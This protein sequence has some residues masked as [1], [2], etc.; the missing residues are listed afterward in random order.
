MLGREL[1]C[2][3][4][5]LRFIRQPRLLG[6]AQDEGRLL[7]RGC[8][9]CDAVPC[10]TTWWSG[11]VQHIAAR[12]HSMTIK[13]CAHTWPSGFCTMRQL[14][15]QSQPLGRATGSAPFQVHSEP[16]CHCWCIPSI[17]TCSQHLSMLHVGDTLNKARAHQ[18]SLL[19]PNPAG[20]H[21]AALQHAHQRPQIKAS[22]AV[23]ELPPFTPPP[24]DTPQ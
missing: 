3:Q 11:A 19:Q 9:C 20:T 5:F 7:M 24:V 2:P 8:T 6:Q 16:S 17:L 23:S 12:G 14:L 18:G 21:R 10:S 4:G 15:R 13:G 1:C 22:A